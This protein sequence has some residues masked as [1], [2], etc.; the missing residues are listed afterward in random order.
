MAL[1][2]DVIDSDVRFLIDPAKR[3]IS[4]QNSTKLILIQGDHNSERFS[5]EIPRTVEGHDMSLCN[6]IRIHYINT[7][8]KTRSTSCD[9][10]EP[11]DMTV[12]TGSTGNTQ[13]VHFSW[14]I[15]NTATVYA[16]SL[17]FAIEF[18]CVVGDK[19]VYSWHT[20]PNTTISISDG[21]SNA[22]AI[23]E[24]YSDILTT[25]W[26]RIFANATLPIEIHDMES[27]AAL[28]GQ[29]A[30]NTLYLL[31]DDPTLEEIEKVIETME[32]H[33]EEYE[34]LDKNLAE[35]LEKYTELDE[36]IADH[37]EDY[38]SLLAR[39]DKLEERVK[40]L[41]KGSGSGACE[42]NYTSVIT[43]PTCGTKGYTTHTC[44]KC[45]NT[46]K[47][48][49]IDATGK[50]TYVDGV[51]TVCGAR[52]TTC[53][54][55]TWIYTQQGPDLWDR[56]CSV[57]KVKEN[58]VEFPCTDGTEH[59]WVEIDATTATCTAAGIRRYMCE[60]CD[61]VKYG[62]VVQE[63]LGHNYVN[64]VCTVCGGSEPDGE[65]CDHTLVFSTS[66]NPTCTEDG[67]ITFICSKC[68]TYTE[69][70]PV[71]TQG[72]T[73][74]E[75]DLDHET[76][77]TCVASGTK[78]YKCR[79]CE[80]LI[81]VEVSALGHNYVESVV[82]DNT[83]TEPAIQ[84]YVCTRCTA[85]KPF[86][87]S[88]IIRP[89]LGHNY[90]NGIC[91]VCG[92]S[93]PGGET[94]DHTLV[95][96][97]SKEPT[98]TEDGYVRFRCSKC[99]IYYEDTVANATGHTLGSPIYDV[100]GAYEPTCS[101]PG[102]AAFVCTKCEAEVWDT[103]PATGDHSWS[104]AIYDAAGYFEPTCTEAG[105]AGYVCTKCGGEKSETVPALQHSYKSVVTPPTCGAKG[106]TTYTCTREGCNYSYIANEVPATGVHSD[107][108]YS[109]VAATCTETGSV[110][111]K[112]SV[113]GYEHTETIPALQHDLTESVTP[114]TCGA[115]GYT[116]YTCT[117]EGCSYG[118]TDNEVPAT[119]AHSDEEDSVVPA[120]CTE[121]GSV[122]YK[123]S[124]CGYE[125]TETTPALQHSYT[126]STVP[127]TCT[128]AGS[129][130]YTCTRE[131]CGYSYTVTI[132][133]LGHNYVEEPIDPDENAN[134]GVSSDGYV[135]VCTRCG[136]R[137]YDNHT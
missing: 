18:Q 34:T 64:G 69:T 51:C 74:D 25:W 126:T 40:V 3:T 43:A 115:E 47:D 20:A 11:D 113:C 58:D 90:V 2:H 29:T 112:C 45:G 80:E 84:K 137:N 22:E 21:I 73:Y 23:V 117:R 30:E 83:C 111:Y 75:N 94:C 124:V 104:D 16:G 33:L 79:V 127:A 85:E 14:L 123:C 131:G 36:N 28:N 10:Y 97:T 42:H 133:P 48:T 89:A 86:E 26:L 37:F 62:E 91:T 66:V 65:T 63:A 32:E 57:C 17:A 136:D 6:V 44:S 81:T 109:V 76:P 60:K 101:T 31:E 88:D 1:I 119:G 116:T 4:N 132:D 134:D 67:S 53:E 5:F 70:T 130:T 125:H 68:N 92:K 71:P 38:E 49:Y 95:F 78:V 50:H 13:V 107:E 135:D 108:E 87:E 61:V 7:C 93:E 99:T 39:L 129:T 35:H 59:S 82:I 118:Y 52:E 120:T 46:Y 110:T 114:P 105:Y 77:A 106:Y 8:S 41:E 122:T 56:Y 19:I 102:Y 12:S 55:H 24:D 15:A 72:H 103:V 121:A 96:D 54:Q 98:C 9:I 27:F 128:A 100:I